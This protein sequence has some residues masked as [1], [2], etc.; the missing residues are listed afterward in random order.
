MLC[1][2]R[3]QSNGAAE[4]PSETELN[5]ICNDP[6]RLAQT[7]TRLSDIGWWMRLLCQKIAVRANK[8]DGEVGKFFQSRYR[9]VRL[10][11]EEA[12]LACS[13][14]VDLNPIRAKL[15]TTIE[16]SDFTSVQRRF[17]RLNNSTITSE[18]TYKEEPTNHDRPAIKKESVSKPLV[19]SKVLNDATPDGFLSPITID[20]FRD[21]LG[22][23]PSS[24][25]MRCSEKGFL[26]MTTIDYLQLL[27]WTARQVVPGKRGSTPDAT[28]G[29]LD[30]LSINANTWLP[31]VTK[32]GKLFNNVAGRPRVIDSTRSRIHQRRFNLRREAREL[33]ETEV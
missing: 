16:E 4:D 29:I 19:A 28:P 24:T 30:R 5:M 21:A 17:E 25:G 13:A 22:A 2:Y 9:A 3:K 20:E 11:D 26:P 10:C 18:R 7:R 1:P 23:N 12:I 31:L 14:Y 33:L 27:E 15:A 32:F 6:I 8:E